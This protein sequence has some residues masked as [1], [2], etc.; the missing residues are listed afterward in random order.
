MVDASQMLDPNIESSRPYYRNKKHLKNV[1]PIRTASQLT[2][3]QQM[4]LAVL[5]RAA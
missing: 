1:G 2:P 5:S 4:S 3:I